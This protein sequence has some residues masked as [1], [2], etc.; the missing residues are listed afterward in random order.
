MVSGMN[1]L[2]V[3]ACRCLLRV[4][5][6][7]ALGALALASRAAPEAGSAQALR[8]MQYQLAD[9]LAHSSLN[10]SVH[11]DSSE[12]PD[13]VQGDVYAIVD[14]PLDELRD[15]L[16]DAAP[17]CEMLMLHIDNRRCRVTR[18]PEGDTL[19]L[20]VVRRYDKPVEQA[21]EIAFDWR[22]ASNA[23]DYLAIDLHAA[24]GPLGTR[25][26]RVALEAVAL[27]PHQ[28]FLHFGYAY[29]HNMM[30]RLATM[31]YLATFGSHKVGFTVVGA[32]ARGRPAYIHG[33]RGLVE[34]NAMRYFL[35]LD[36]YL[37][38]V[39]VPAPQ[40]FEARLRQWF[41]AIA[42]Y[43]EQLDETDLATYLA[44]KRADRERE[45]AAR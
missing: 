21:I 10:R 11:L 14:H 3:I 7:L 43:P 38:G 29:D 37:D 22:N 26:Y 31:A 34:R 40:R 20:S 1:R 8:D 25:N 13:G 5:L 16:G 18:R 17:W 9:A 33:L 24:A 35:T 41:G 36:A 12:T 15:T 30:A 4:G 44:L 6:G 32:D 2:R 45:A 27:N 23:R 28:T 42:Q 19:T 39:A